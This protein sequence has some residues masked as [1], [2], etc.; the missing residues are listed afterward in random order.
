MCV[1]IYIYIKADECKYF[2]YRPVYRACVLYRHRSLNK[3][4]CHIT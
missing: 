4:D 3:Y 1:Y 2:L